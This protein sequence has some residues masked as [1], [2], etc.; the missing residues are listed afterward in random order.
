MPRQTRKKAPPIPASQRDWLLR[1]SR[2]T[3][4]VSEVAPALA[5]ALDISAEG[6]RVRIYRAIERGEVQSRTYLGAIR[7]PRSEVERIL[8]GEA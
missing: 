1:Q 2:A 6:A 3:Y 5:E 7:V 8:S 4:R